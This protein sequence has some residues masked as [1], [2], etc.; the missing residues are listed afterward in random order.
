MEAINVYDLKGEKLES[1]DKPLVF[2]SVIRKDLVKKASEIHQS[3]SKQKKGRDRR[4][5]LRNTAVSW[6]TGHA[7]SRAPRIK[8]SGFSTARNVGR[9]PFAVG[10]RVTHP[11]KVQKI[12]IKR[13]NKKVSSL[14][15]KSAISA[16]ADSSLITS[17]GHN[18]SNIPEIPL[19]IDDKIQTVKKTNQAYQILCN[20]GLENELKQVKSKR[21]IRAGKGKGRG[22]KYK[23][24]KS[25]LLVIS[26][27]FG[28]VNALKNIP[29]VDV[30]KMGHLS[31]EDLAP[32]GLLGR[33]VV[34]TRSA[35][36]EL[37]INGEE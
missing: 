28:I 35:I 5:G 34:W 7:L 26:E 12:I 15:L 24:R 8:G 3:R 11:I 1:I 14:A 17:R 20:I 9:V 37:N 2:Q 33:L 23:N 10:G 4:A 30:V 22:R 31:I 13:I 19:V 16:S 18:I 36:K 29:G 6:G 25:I 27:D 32:G 21:K